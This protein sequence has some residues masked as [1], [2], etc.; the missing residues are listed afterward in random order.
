MLIVVSPAKALDFS[1]PLPTKKHS[2]PR[3]LEDTTHLVEV[4]RRK[5][6]HELA[7][8]MNISSKLAELNRQRFADWSLPLTPQT[9]RPALLAFTG[10]AYQAIDA[11]NTFDQRDYTHAQKTLR[12][13]S[14][15]YG[16]LRPLDL[17]Q[18]YRLEMNS[19][20]S[21]QQGRNLYE[22]W[23]ERITRL[24]ETDLQSAPGA[25]A[26]LNLA[27]KQYFQVVQPAKIGGRIITPAF[28]DGK[29]R[30]SPTAKTTKT[31]SD[32]TDRLEKAAEMPSP[33]AEMIIK[34]PRTIGFHAKRARG[35]MAAWMIRNRIKTIN[36]ISEFNGLGYSYDTKRSTTLN[37]VFVRW[38]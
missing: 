28:L 14:G 27:S 17:I 13:L 12:I 5:Q 23:G 19:R 31:A 15:L 24:L 7:A 1:S 37:P 3:M 33:T 29:L 10:D 16:V 32:Q 9:A 18:P 35:A 26:I 25:K 6:P 22:F 34:E 8:M 4:L 21:T 11:S 20:L 30:S 2:Q 36:K 38:Q